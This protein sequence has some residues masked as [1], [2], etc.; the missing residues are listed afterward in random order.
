MRSLLTL[1]ILGD[2]ITLAQGRGVTPGLCFELRLSTGGRYQKN[3]AH[4]LEAIGPLLA[5]GVRQ[6][7]AAIVATQAPPL[8]YFEGAFRAVFPGTK[9]V[10]GRAPVGLCRTTKTFK[11]VGGQNKNFGIGPAAIVRARACADES[12]TPTSPRTV[13]ID[14]T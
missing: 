11:G 4:Q 9:L 6:Q 12:T 10:K 1:V 7:P 14:P 8:P 2:A 3:L 13:T 5:A